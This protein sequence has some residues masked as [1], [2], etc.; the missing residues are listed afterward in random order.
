MHGSLASHIMPRTTLD[1]D[2]SVL[3]ELRRRGHSEGRSMG[4]V[5]SELLAEGLARSEREDGAPLFEWATGKLGSPRVDLRTARHW[6]DSSTGS[7]ERY[8]R[9][10]RLGLRIE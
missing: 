10:Q 2:G 9:R 6:R 7:R 3:R 4:R 8:G 1:I 5:A